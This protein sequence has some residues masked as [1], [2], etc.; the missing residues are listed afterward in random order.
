MVVSGV[1]TSADFPKYVAQ[2]GRAEKYDSTKEKPLP[3]PW[4]DVNQSDIQNGLKIMSD[5]VMKVMVGIPEKDEELMHVRS[6]AEG[7]PHINYRPP[8]KIALLGAQGAGKS[9]LLNALFDTNGLSLTGAD[10]AACTSAIIEYRHSSAANKIPGADEYIAQ[11]HFMHASKL[12]EMLQEHARSYQHFFEDDDSDDEE[13][14]VERKAKTRYGRRDESD[15]RLKDT[16]MEIFSTLF[17]GKETFVESWHASESK[18]SEFVNLCQIQCNQA[19]GKLDLDKSKI[20]TYTG[21]DPETLLKK[22]R[23]FMTKVKGED[24]LWPLVD[25]IT[26]EFPSRLLEENLLIID[27]P[28]WGDVNVFRTRHSDE[29]KDTVD[30]ELIVADTIR[31]ATDDAVISSARS[32]MMNHGASGVKLVA[33]KTDVISDNQLAQCSGPRYDTIQSLI[34]HTQ[35]EI[36]QA[37]D[38]DDMARSSELSRYRTYLERKRKSVKIEERTKD[39][40]KELAMKLNGHTKED[41]VQCFHVSAGDY[42]Q[43]IA[44]DKK[45][46][47]FRDQPSLWPEMTS[48]PALRSLLRSLPAQQNLEDIQQYVDSHV[49]AFLDKVR[50]VVT[51]SDRDVGFKTLAD[52]FDVAR[53]AYRKQILEQLRK[54]CHHIAKASMKKAESD[55]ENYKD[56]IDTLVNDSWMKP[57]GPTLNKILKGKGT[58][59][60]FTSKAKGLEDGCNWDQDLAAILTPAFQRWYNEQERLMKPMRQAVKE[61]IEFMFNGTT[62]RIEESQASVTTI[63]KAK[64]R[65]QPYRDRLTVKMDSLMDEIEELQRKLLR[66]A[67]MEDNRQNSFIPELTGPVWDSV[68]STE[69]EIKAITKEGRKIFKTPKLRFQREMLWDHFCNSDSHFVD[70]ALKAFLRHV[71]E[72]LDGVVEKYIAEMDILLSAYSSNLR[73]QAPIPY[74]LTHD[75]ERIRKELE[76]LIP[77]LEKHAADLR[78]CLPAKVRTEGDAQPSQ[79]N[80]ALAKSKSHGFS[81]D[82]HYENSVKRKDRNPNVRIKQEQNTGGAKRARLL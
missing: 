72:A 52:D 54:W 56:T 39:I 2:Y 68:F 77:S 46:I 78:D 64:K 31:I 14:D 60:P 9:L 32:A 25:H 10:G 28:G 71:K 53:E 6:V 3:H 80:A 20:G 5:I 49:P 33:T 11:V 21:K 66:R 37:D 4:R 44:K 61:L 26:I 1:I 43:W 30:V 41:I 35:H 55:A 81:L 58:I 67:T 69:P 62:I 23:P 48:I 65:W 75:G 51:D 45:L 15:R 22:I 27:L 16:A 79:S 42:M 59:L 40:D 57:R 76:Q 24:S 7:L 34:K 74:I 38:E 82:H 17:G 36:E 12:E 13:S 47:M 8:V 63:E 18:I 70:K 73:R 29:I 50:R 19:L